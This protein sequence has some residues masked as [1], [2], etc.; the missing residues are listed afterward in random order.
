MNKTWKK[1]AI[2]AGVATSAMATAFLTAS[3][4]TKY[5]MRI[6]LNRE[7]PKTPKGTGK[8]I[9]GAGHSGRDFQHALDEA[10][11]RLSRQENETVTITASDG[12][13]LV[14]HWIPC[15]QPERILIA[16]HGWRSTWH[17]DF[18]LIADFWHNHGCSVL[19]AEQR[20]QGNSGGEYMGFGLT[21]RF[22]CLDWVHWVNDRFGTELPIYLCGVSM[23]A[24]TVLMAADLALP[25][26][27]H[28]IGADCGFTSPEAIWRHIASNNLHISFGLCGKI[29]DEILKR[30]IKVESGDDSTMEALENTKIPVL[31]IHGTDDAFVPVEMTYE[32][33]KACAGPKKLLVVPGAGH[34]MSY[35]VDRAGYEA[36]TLDF[37]RQYDAVSPMGCREST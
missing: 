8:R 7:P 27:V 36:A 26:N 29:A 5:L 18:G 34:G 31:F 24:T 25:E 3:A 20:G 12:I 16:M 11:V 32:N 22:D 28:G 35:Y 9:T 17:H 33:Y 2:T 21:E 6:A 4:A 30:K 15:E 23:G 1:A 19:Y 37:W 14:G 13:A 10:S